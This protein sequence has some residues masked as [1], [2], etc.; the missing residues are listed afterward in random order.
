MTKCAKD[1]NSI[2]IIPFLLICGLF[3]LLCGPGIASG[4][5]IDTDVLNGII[6]AQGKHWVAKDYPERKGLGALRKTSNILHADL[7]RNL[8]LQ[9]HY[10]LNSIGTTTLIQVM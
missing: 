1:S 9:C 8:W 4:Q 7:S 2:F 6:K 10:R 5:N 3:F